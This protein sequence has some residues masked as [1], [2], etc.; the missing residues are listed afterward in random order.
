MATPT[1]SNENPITRSMGAMILPKAVSAAIK[2]VFGN[3]NTV[4]GK[5]LV[6]RAG[7]GVGRD[8]LPAHLQSLHAPGSVGGTSDPDFLGRDPLQAIDLGNG[9][10]HRLVAGDGEAINAVA[11][12][13]ALRHDVVDL[14]VVS[15]DFQRDLDAIEELQEV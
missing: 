2:P 1:P 11:E 4:A 5:D 13:G 3:E 15:V 9:I 8:V 14:A 6:I 10:E 7:V 12:T